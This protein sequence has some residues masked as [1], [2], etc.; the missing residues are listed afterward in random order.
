[1]FTVETTA[2]EGDLA[3]KDA[4]GLT[5]AEVFERAERE[6]AKAKKAADASTRS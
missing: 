2:W 1:M 6:K 3:K 5:P 4:L